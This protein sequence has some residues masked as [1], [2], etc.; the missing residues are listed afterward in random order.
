M[1]IGDFHLVDGHRIGPVV[2]GLLNGHAPAIPRL[3]DHAGDDVDVDQ[4]EAG[5]LDP[6][7]HPID[8][9]G[10]MRPAVDLEDGVVEVLHAQAQTSHA[11]LADGLELGLAESSRL[12]LEGDLLWLLA[13]E[14]D[15]FRRAARLDRCLAE[16]NEGVP[17]PK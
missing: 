17:P 5:L 13:R 16:M 11:D 8:F 7:P 6:G 3:A 2:D 1:L 10:H 15:S 12:A 14:I 4:V 9:L